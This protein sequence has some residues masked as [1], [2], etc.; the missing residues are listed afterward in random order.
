MRSKKPFTAMG[1]M[2]VLMVVP[3]TAS[4]SQWGGWIDTVK[5]PE[6]VR[7]AFVAFKVPEID[8]KNTKINKGSNE[9]SFWAGIGGTK[10]KGGKSTETLL[11]A[12]VS[13]GMWWDRRSKSYTPHY[14]VW[15]E[16]VAGKSKNEVPDTDGEVQIGDVQPRDDV[17]VEVWDSRRTVRHNDRQGPDMN[18]GITIGDLTQGKTWMRKASHLYPVHTAEAVVERPDCKPACTFTA[19]GFAYLD[20]LM[21][22]DSWVGKHHDPFMGDWGYLTP[23][24]YNPQPNN[25]QF[26]ALN[27]M[28]AGGI[29]RLATTNTVR[30]SPSCSRITHCTSWEFNIHWKHA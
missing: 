21:T 25:F 24:A 8:A 20:P 12:G 27:L 1:A 16:T 30:V 26:Q 10:P 19:F 22:L 11:Q 4:A 15:W 17:Y 28:G 6:A 2:A 14:K 5:S 3:A 29:R 13:L 18:W 23:R 7:G 9:A